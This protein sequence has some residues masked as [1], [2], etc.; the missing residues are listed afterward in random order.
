MRKYYYIVI[1]LWF[2]F[3]ASAIGQT[4]QQN[5][6][7]SGGKPFALVIGIS[8]YNYLQSWNLNHPADEAKTMGEILVNQGYDVRELTNEKATRNNILEELDALCNRRDVNDLILVYLTGHGDSWLNMTS[9]CDSATF[10][11]FYPKLNDCFIDR[12]DKNDF[13]FFPTYQTEKTGFLSEAIGAY[14]IVNRMKRSPAHKK[15]LII[16]A[17]YS[18]R[19]APPAYIPVQAISPIIKE[20]GFFCLINLK[21]KVRDGLDSKIMFKGL[22][23]LADNNYSGNND[24]YV[25]AYELAIYMEAELREIHDNSDSMCHILIGEGQI[26]ISRY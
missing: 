7:H 18:N 25:S 9:C 19:L 1:L 24:G 5:I 3:T 21:D 4:Q 20:E 10:N 2:S 15:I 11:N 14:Q 8:K 23:G 6:L 13:L 16:D 12:P 22:Q 17:C 26:F